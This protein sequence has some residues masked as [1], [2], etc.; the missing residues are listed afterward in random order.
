MAAMRGTPATPDSLSSSPE[1][2]YLAA[3]AVLTTFD[4]ETLRPVSPVK[5]D[6]GGAD[7]GDDFSRV[8]AMLARHAEPIKIGP[9]RGR[10]RLRDD[11]RRRVLRLLGSREQIQAALSAN[12]DSRPNDNTQRALV[13]LVSHTTPP[14]LAGR[15]LDD[16]LGWDRAVDWLEAA[17][18]TPLPS[19]ARIL[20]HIERHKLFEPMTRLVVGFAGRDEEMRA[21]RAYVDHLPSETVLEAFSRFA[22]R[23]RDAFRG[24]PPLVIH[25]PGGAGKSTLIAKFILDHAGP[26]RTQPMAFVLLDFD[27]SN[28]DPVRPDALLTEVAQQVRTQFPDL[29]VSSESLIA[30]A[31]ASLA[32]EDA[33]DYAKTD[34]DASAVA[35]HNLVSL[36]NEIASRGNRNILF[37]LDTFEIVQRRG[38]TAVYSLLRFVAEILVEVP[39]LRVVIVGRGVLRKQDFPFADDMPEWT[40]MPLR[41]FD[42]VAGR[43]YLRARLKPYDL[44]P[45]SDEQLDR[46]VQQVNGNPLGLRLAAQVFAREGLKGV[47]EAIGRQRLSAA[48]AEERIQGLLHARIVEHLE[49]E[50]LKKLADPGLIVRRLT[51][52]VVR[53]VLAKPCG[54][55]FDETTP[56]SLFAALGNEV[57]L[58]EVVDDKTVRHRPDVR[59]I[60]LPSQRRRLRDLAR[61]IDDAAVRYWEKFPGPAERAEELY[62]RM[63]RGDAVADLERRWMPAAGPLLEEALDEFLVV[64]PE[65]AAR[66]WLSEKLDRELPEDVRRQADRRAWE[67]DVERKA[68]TLM[69][70]SRFDEAQRVIHER[71]VSEWTDNSPLWLIDIDIWLLKK[72]GAAQAGEV[73]RVALKRLDGTDDPDLALALLLR[74]VSAEERMEDRT[75]AYKWAVESLAMARSLRNPVSIFACGVALMRLA[76]QTNRLGQPDIVSLKTELVGLSKHEAVVA[77]LPERPSLIRESA[78]ELGAAAPELLIVALERLGLKTGGSRG[79][80]VHPARLTDELVKLLQSQGARF[81]QESDGSTSMQI[82]RTAFEAIANSIRRGQI[83]GESLLALS[84]LYA[85][86]V[87]DLSRRTF[88]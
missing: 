2:P 35:R 33:A 77:A 73:I 22:G 19:R 63:W 5:T 17:R 60:M 16:L 79:S 67:R 75:S 46:L 54:I 55:T 83:T 26:D 39:R 76:R 87:D 44:P 6:T 31:N 52:D 34:F 21:L 66:I 80:G 12:V 71:P 69:A 58:V 14:P 30:A 61:Q 23:I 50:D 49:N 56:E 1:W 25:G 42:P 51:V 48:V 10:W 86:N 7:G 81:I 45:V 38:P 36:L 70:S 13:E 53:D 4:A 57:S 68:R 82:S 74:R 18:I 85:A 15:S 78:A 59:L 40:P 8:S 84:A 27:R 20:G 41:G 43:A 64:A 62:H 11:V 88:S 29:E 9:A 37:V 28:L 72:D 24:R 32:A 47:E 65:G 3:S